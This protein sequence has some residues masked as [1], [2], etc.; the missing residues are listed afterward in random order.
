MAKKITRDSKIWE[1]LTAAKKHLSNKPTD[2]CDDFKGKCQYICHAVSYALDGNAFW[3][4][5]DSKA[6]DYIM[7]QLEHHD[8]LEV[9]LCDTKGISW[10][11]LDSEE[12]GIKLQT[13]RK[14]W[15]NHMIKECKA[16]D[17]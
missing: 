13:T 7:E 5:R 8:S 3:Y 15:L 16:K 17:I 6:H 2:L 1:I 4:D 11:D 9:W 10:N 12:G 14:A